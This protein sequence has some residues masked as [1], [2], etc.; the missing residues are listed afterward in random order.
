MWLSDMRNLTPK[1]SHF[2]HDLKLNR[3]KAY[4][5]SAK[6]DWFQHSAEIGPIEIY[7]RENYTCG[8]INTYSL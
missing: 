1:E 7:L 4:I 6:R 5:F 8:Q 3:N 2:L